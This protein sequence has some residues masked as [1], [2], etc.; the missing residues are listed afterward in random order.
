MAKMNYDRVIKENQIMRAKMSAYL[1]EI[2]INSIRDGNYERVSKDGRFFAVNKEIKVHKSIAGGLREEVRFHE[3]PHLLQ[4]YVR[5]MYRSGAE[6]QLDN[7]SWTYKSDGIG[8]CFHYE[9]YRLEN[10]KR[11]KK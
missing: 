6:A 3:I 7:Q 8:W 10:V 9:K 11:R 5:E 1:N 2:N 4:W